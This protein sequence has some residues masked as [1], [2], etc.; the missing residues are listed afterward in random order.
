[1]F[2]KLRT[3][4]F[5]VLFFLPTIGIA[6]QKSDSVTQLQEVVIEQSRL[7]SYAISNYTLRVDSLT[8]QLSSAGSLADLLRKHGFGHLRSYG[9][10]GLASASFR[11]TGSSH[12]AVLWNGIN[13]LSPLSGQLDLSQVPVSFIDDA[14]VQTG[15]AASLYGN[16]SIGG[17]I[18][19]NN[20]AQFSEG[21]KLNTFGSTG[22]FGSY[23][24]D[25]GA[26][27]SGKKFITSTKVFFSEA[28]NDFEFLNKSVFPA[29]EEKRVHTAVRQRGILQ[30]NYWQPSAQH[31]LT[32]KFWYQDN[33][34]QVPNPTSVPR[35][36]V[37]VEQ[38]TFYRAVAGWHFDHRLFDLS[39]QGAFVKHD[40]NYADSV[41]DLNYANSVIYLLSKNTF[42]TSINNVELNFSLAKNIY[43]TSGLNYTWE[44]GIVDAFGNEVPQRNRA[45]VFSALKWMPATKWELAAAF[46]EEMV[47]GEYMP[48][49]PSLTTKFKLSPGVSFYG[50]LSRNYRI[51]TF[52]DLY[53]KGAGGIGSANL[54]TETSL[55]NE[56]GFSYSS[57][58]KSF[59]H[60]SLLVKAAIFSNHVTDWIQWNPLTAAVWSPQNIKK[61]WSRGIE[62]QGNARMV[63][64]QVVME[65]SFQYTFTRSTNDDIYE[66]ATSN[67]LNKQLMLTPTHEGSATA[68]AIWKGYTLNIVSTYTGKQ[69]TDSDNN[70]FNALKAYS[71]SSLWFNKAISFNTVK[72]TL[73]SE[74]N[75]IFDV[76]YQS[77]QG[78]PMPGINYKVG[79]IFHFNKPNQL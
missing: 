19:L 21:L 46:R 60:P 70:E 6:Q 28:Q 75:N 27:W 23:Y 64:S 1:M 45:A 24:Q 12:T 25:L 7:G 42:N 62:A 43:V 77:R 54:K 48:V 31:L 35:K 22:S 20:K 14:S 67:E 69:Y 66:N 71:V 18:Q 4:V 9:P 63:M 33:T 3:Y 79:V 38:N 59:R 68:R 61:V 73:M 32:F 34:Y 16:G 30:Q 44:Q 51:P 74:V 72:V 52:N 39:Y 53:W 2:A 49:A 65:L 29:K 57:N 36:A 8:N 17:T 15:G 40:L 55:S 56:V 78:Y 37:A 13:L 10:G 5:G 47:N 11:G 26:S 41:I 58:A 76:S 50:S